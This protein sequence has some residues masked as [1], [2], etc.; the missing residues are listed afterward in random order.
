MS[1]RNRSKA[2]ALSASSSKAAVSC[3]TF[4]R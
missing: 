3:S 2:C 1:A 4:L